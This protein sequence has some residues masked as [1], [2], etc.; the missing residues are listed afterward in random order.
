MNYLK[1]I[2]FLVTIFLF[3]SCEKETFEPIVDDTPSTNDVDIVP[4]FRDVE[5]LLVESYYVDKGGKKYQKHPFFSFTTPHL[6]SGPTPVDTII[7]NSPSVVGTSWVIEQYKF[8]LNGVTILEEVSQSDPKLVFDGYNRITLYFGWTNRDYFINRT[9]LINEGVLEVKTSENA[10]VGGNYYNVLLFTKTAGYTDINDYYFPP[11]YNVDGNLINN[12]SDNSVS[13][14]LNGQTWLLTDITSN[15][16]TLPNTNFPYTIVFN[17]DGTYSVDGLS[18]TNR[19]YRV[20]GVPFYPLVD[21]ELYDF[22]PMG[23]GNFVVKVS[24]TSLQDGVVSGSQIKNIYNL[25]EPNR[26]IYMNRQ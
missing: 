20:V 6:S 2:I 3:S 19:R 23:G 26:L 21:L 8:I 16:F 15:G 1:L 18:N 24:L 22:S 13:S 11:D 5:W 17:N 25:S 14:V 12:I 7:K 10:S 4:L 9:R